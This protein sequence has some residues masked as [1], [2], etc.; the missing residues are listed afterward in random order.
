[1]D[2]VAALQLEVQQ[3]RSS[4]QISARTTANG[5]DE[6]TFKALVEANTVSGSLSEIH[7][8]HVKPNT[9]TSITDTND[10]QHTEGTRTGSHDDTGNMKTVLEIKI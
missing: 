2:Q 5:L 10:G 9:A 8:K 7:E 4:A 6:E 3:V 1:M